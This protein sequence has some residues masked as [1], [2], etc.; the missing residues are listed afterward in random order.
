MRESDTARRL[1][2]ALLGGAIGTLAYWLLL[3]Q[4]ILLLAIV[5]GCLGVLGGLWALRRSRAWGIGLAVAGTLLTIG[6]EWHFRPFVADESLGYF[7]THLH[8]LTG[9]T[10]LSIAFAAFFGYYFGRGKDSPHSTAA[11]PGGKGESPG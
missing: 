7:L 3:R 6:V 4:G 10:L 2:G 8:D 5:G 1:L 11:E 9:R